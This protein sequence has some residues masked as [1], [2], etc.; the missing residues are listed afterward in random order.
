MGE[1]LTKAQAQRVLD[2]T[3]YCQRVAAVLG[4]NAVELLDALD[5]CNVT[6]TKDDHDVIQDH[7]EHI[8]WIPHKGQAT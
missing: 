6:L 8:A 2:L 7:I 4:I 1:Q 5:M 3:T